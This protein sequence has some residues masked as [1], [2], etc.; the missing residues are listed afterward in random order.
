ME[1][2]NEAVAPDVQ[3]TGVVGTDPKSV[4]DE[5]LVPLR[6]FLERGDLKGAWEFVKEL[7]QRWP[8]SERVR[9]YIHVFAPSVARG[10]PDSARRSFQRERLW[11]KEHA[12]EFPGCWI[13]VIE[14]R[15]VVA[16]PDLG[17]VLDTMRQTPGAE[18]A[19]VHF[20][21]GPNP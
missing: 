8:D 5:D 21:P 4:I 6:G 11:L 17:V 10:A 16:N 2:R 19:L 20:Q 14:D 3:A 18:T 13:A 15:F 9:H 7:Q 1:K 12:H